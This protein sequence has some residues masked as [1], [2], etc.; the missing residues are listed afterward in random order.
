MKYLALLFPLLA[1]ASAS[2]YNERAV[3][4][5]S[6]YNKRAVASAYNKRDVELDDKQP[7]QP[8][9]KQPAKPPAKGPAKPP[10]KPPVKGPPT[11]PKEPPLPPNLVRDANTFQAFTKTI[12]EDPFGLVK[13]WKGPDPCKYKGVICETK[14]KTKTLAVAGIDINSANIGSGLA[15][16]GLLN[17]LVDL[18]FFHAN[19]NKFAGGIPNLSA[20]K[21]LYELDLSNNN[22]TGPFP[23]AILSAPELL[24]LDLRFNNLVGPLP[25]G[26]FKQD[27]E[28]IWLNHNKLS[29]PI[30]P[31]IGKS[32]VKY[33]TIAENHFSGP[34]PASVA[35]MKNLKEGIFANNAL[36]G[37][38]PDKLCA[39][40]G[41]VILD[42]RG[43]KLDARLGPACTAL[44]KAKKLLV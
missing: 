26:L 42:F 38:I 27:L 34:I 21:Y 19:S 20:S 25:A 10:A 37:A 5:A 24:L 18:V 4:S 23:P 11:P 3:A 14:P 2:P 16:D 7:V 6:L 28:T 41:L 1:V 40:K 33:F 30:P 8:P 39:K 15:L 9:A 31:E 22:L 12:K 43:N 29:G 17:K 32:P 44:K 35:D 13:A 36:T